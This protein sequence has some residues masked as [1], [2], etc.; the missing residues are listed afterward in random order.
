[1]EVSSP[2]DKAVDSSLYSR[3]LYVMGF[4]AQRRM[5]MSNVL[6]VGLN[7]LGVEVAKNIILAGV[8]SVAILDNS[9]VAHN[10]LASQFYCD[11]SS[12]GQPRAAVSAPKLAELN[13]YVPVTVITDDP[14]PELVSAYSV[15]VLI[16]VQEGLKSSIADYCHDHGIAV[17]ASDLFGVFGNIFCD[18]GESFVVSD[19]DGEPAATSLIASI[20]Q[21]NPALIHALDETRHHLSTGDIVELSGITGMDELNGK[22]FRINVKD[23]NSFEIDVDTSGYPAYKVGG[24]VKQVKRNHK[25]TLCDSLIN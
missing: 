24:Y 7:G 17:I 5:A 6:I 8:K 10:D 3:Q 15:V 9:P 13:P 23:P 11:E 12:I 2:Q 21:A 1:M 25:T 14:S 20:T 19:V 16:D 22:K 18:F 4:E